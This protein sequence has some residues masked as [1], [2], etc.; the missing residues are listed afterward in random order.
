VSAGTETNAYGG[1][2]DGFV[3]RLSADLAASADDRLSWLGGAGAD[4]V[5]A[6][7]V[8]DGQVYLAGQTDGELAG[9]TALGAKDGFLVRMDAA[10]GAVGWSRRFTDKDGQAAPT[11]IA[12]AANGASVLDRLGLPKGTLDYTGSR[13]V[14]AATSLRPGD[15]FL[16]RTREGAA[17]TAVTIAADDTLQT[18]ALK[19][20]RA[21]GFNAQAVV[22]KDGDVDRLQ[23]KPRNE[24]T[25]VEILPGKGERD[26]LTALGLSEGVVRHSTYDAAKK[27]DVASAE[28]RLYG[29][30]LGRDL[31]LDDPEQIKHALAEL[32]AAMVVIR[33]AYRDLRN[34]ATPP[35]LR[36]VTGQPSP[37]MQRQIAGYE[38]ALR[39]LGG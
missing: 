16:V 31:N 18:L 20:N 5:T 12:V 33:T 1:G 19:I 8:K 34:D 24:R 14:T 23:I 6:M 27:E 28:G 17:P 3:A 36:P 9:T 13:R 29:L 7:A 39:R 37:Y 22:V 35:A 2:R 32:A 15:Q 21:L 30:K 38:E 4:A 11:S 10:T 26:A 25:F